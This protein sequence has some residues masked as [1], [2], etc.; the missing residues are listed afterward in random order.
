MFQEV[1]DSAQNV[2]NGIEE[3]MRDQVGKTLVEEIVSPM[4]QDGQSMQQAYEIFKQEKEVIQGIMN[5]L[6]A[7]I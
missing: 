6:R 1:I 5:T 7:M 2:R 4:I 3:N